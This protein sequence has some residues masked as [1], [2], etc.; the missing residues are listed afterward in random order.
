MTDLTTKTNEEL[1]EIMRNSIDNSY[2][3]SSSYNKAKQELEFRNASKQENT[4]EEIFKL[5]PELY[6]IGINLKAIWRK[7]KSYFKS[8]NEVIKK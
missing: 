2:V 5:S 7:L 6:G 4:K 1:K 8:K 3:P